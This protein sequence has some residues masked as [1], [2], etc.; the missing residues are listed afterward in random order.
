MTEAPAAPAL[1][2]CLPTLFPDLGRSNDAHLLAAVQAAAD[3]GFQELDLFASSFVQAVESAVA[4]GERE[5]LVPR[6]DR[7]SAIA[8]FRAAALRWPQ[9][10]A[11]PEAQHLRNE[12]RGRGLRVEA[13]ECMSLWPAGAAAGDA[14]ARAICEVAQFLGARYVVAVCLSPDMDPADGAEG[15]RRAADIA[16]E[17]GLEVCLEWL[18][19]TAVPSIAAGWELIQRSAAANVGFT[20]DALHWQ[21]QPGGPDWVT[22]RSLPADTVRFLQLSDCRLPLP[23]GVIEPSRRLLPGEGDIDLLRLLEELRGRG[24]QPT[25]SVE[26]FDEESLMQRGLRAFA[27]QQGDAL[28]AVLGIAASHA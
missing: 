1:T 4:G 17:H 20:F 16:A 10:L 7:R 22:L 18:P 21:C 6:A 8:D 27:G 2:F 23:D 25:P 28:R 19:G 13:V 14:D 12:I 15:L 3:A 24:M 11:L 26:V 5:Q 9:A